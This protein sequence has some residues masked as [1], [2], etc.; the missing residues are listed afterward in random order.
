MRNTT[1]ERVV[2]PELIDALP[3]TDPLAIR[4][5]RDLR[6]VNAW[7]GNPKIMARALQQAF[8]RNPPGR[9]A[10]IGAGD[11]ELLLRVARLLNWR[12]LNA[13]LVDRQD[14]LKL[15]TRAQ[16]EQMGWD[17]RLE[18]SDVFDWL[19]HPAAGTDIIAANLFLHHFTGE[20]LRELFRAAAKTARVFIAVEPRRAPPCLFFSH[21]L[22]FIGCNR[23]TRHDAVVSVQAGFAGSELSALWP[24]RDGWNLTEQPA[25]FASHLFVAQR[26]G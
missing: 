23:V 18:K 3:P 25:R 2:E 8:P 17:V 24:D 22:W 20:Q 13:T 10:E 6:R 1:I 26:K 15:E 5:R 21:L 19:Q 11:G 14:I 12:S 4:T 16:F 9:I 7:M